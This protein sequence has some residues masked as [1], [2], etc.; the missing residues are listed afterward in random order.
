LIDV[1]AREQNKR[2]Q[3]SAAGTHHGTVRHVGNENMRHRTPA[4]VVASV[5]GFTPDAFGL[6]AE[7]A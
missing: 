6:M 4:E 5:S 7:Y 1:V 2:F 3:R